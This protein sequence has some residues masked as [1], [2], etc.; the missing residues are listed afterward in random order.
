MAKN[1]IVL[2]G[3]FGFF[4][5][6]LVSW[7][8]LRAKPFMLGLLSLI[9][10]VRDVILDDAGV[11]LAVEAVKLNDPYY[12][13]PLKESEEERHAWKTFMVSYIENATMT[14]GSGPTQRR[15]NHHKTAQPDLR[16]TGGRR[17]D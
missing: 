16:K 1:T 10:Q 11:A 15:K 13:K 7:G 14:H 5:S 2:L 9:N 17:G 8:S 6:L 12:P 3:C 4:A